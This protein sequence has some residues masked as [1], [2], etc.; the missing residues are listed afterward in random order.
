M[1]GLLTA[2]AWADTSTV[3]TGFHYDDPYTLVG[4]ANFMTGFPPTNSDG[5]V[6]VVIEIPAGSIEKWETDKHSGAIRWEFKNGEPRIVNYLGYPGNYG[7]IP[8]TLLPK[9]QGGDGDPLDVLVLGPAIPRGS[10]VKVRLVGVLKL[11]DEG[12][13]DDKLLAVL[14][15]TPLAK[16]KNLSDLA[17]QFNGVNQ[18]IETWFTNYKGQG[19]IESLGFADV[20]E[21]K[22]ILGTAAAAYE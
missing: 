14:E 9:E 15:D 1:I 18:I 11:L 22:R 4:E 13:Q 8:R 10:V 2:G 19:K 3:P 12:E 17:I 16:A 7:M 20:E 6:N 21:A 5:T